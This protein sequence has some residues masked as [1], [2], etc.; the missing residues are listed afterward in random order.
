MSATPAANRR[1]LVVDDNQAIHQDFRKILCAPPPSPTLDAMEADDAVG[2]YLG[3][4]RSEDGYRFVQHVHVIT[5]ET[6]A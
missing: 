3:G 1:I 4:C 6:A 2:G 5:W